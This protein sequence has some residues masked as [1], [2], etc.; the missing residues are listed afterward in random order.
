MNFVFEMI[1]T[2]TEGYILALRENL[3]AQRDWGGA[4]VDGSGMFGSVIT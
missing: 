1:A 3:W 2:T 4:D